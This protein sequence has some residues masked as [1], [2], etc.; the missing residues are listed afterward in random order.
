MAVLNFFPGGGSNKLPGSVSASPSS[1]TAPVNGTAT[2]ALTVVGDGALSASSSDTSIATVAISGLTLTVTGVAAGN[3]TITVNLAASSTYTKASCTVSVSVAAYSPVL[4]NNT[5]GQIKSAVDAGIADTLWDVGDETAQ[6]AIGA[7]TTT[8]GSLAQA[9]SLSAYI[10][11]FNHNSTIE[12]EGIQFL[13]GKNSNGD[14]CALASFQMNTPY[15]E[16]GWGASAMRTEICP[17][18]YNALPSEWKSVISTTTKWSNK[19]DYMSDKGMEALTE[20]IFIPSQYEVFGVKGQFAE[21]LETNQVQYAYYA[22]GNS[23]QKCKHNDTSVLDQW[24]LRTTATYPSGYMGPFCTVKTDGAEW[25][26]S[27]ADSHGFAP[28][29]RIGPTSEASS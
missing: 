20:T 6:I 8:H 16:N 14:D 7:F 15:N 17:A 11:G 26:A 4:A 18:F 1:V 9:T 21:R 19:D 27:A 3:A 2:A 25:L 22:N 28:A 29:F 24:W 13:F 10:I 5:P 12:G 23:K